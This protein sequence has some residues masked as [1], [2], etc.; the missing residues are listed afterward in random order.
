VTTIISVAESIFEIK[1]PFPKGI[2]GHGYFNLQNEQGLQGHLKLA[3]VENIAFVSRPRRNKPARYI[4][5]YTDDGHCIW[6][7]YLGRNSDGEL[8]ESQ[9]LAFD[10]LKEDLTHG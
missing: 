7:I 4:G 3:N 6:K 5:F 2:V 8:F 10:Q 1:G 9:L